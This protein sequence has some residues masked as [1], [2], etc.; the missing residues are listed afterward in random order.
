[1]AGK[2]TF[3]TLLIF[4]TR[5]PKNILMGKI[6]TETN[7]KTYDFIFM[8]SSDKLDIGA[9]VITKT[10]WSTIKTDHLP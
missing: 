10:D 2:F 1:M 3:S 8:D 6:D 4:Q 5:N 9:L 7:H